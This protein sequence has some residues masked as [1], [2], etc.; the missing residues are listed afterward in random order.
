MLIK[1]RE[2]YRGWIVKDKI[3][4]LA[5]EVYDMPG[6][7]A[8]YLIET[9][10][11]YAEALKAIPGPKAAVIP[12]RLG[13]VVTEQELMAPTAPATR[14]EEALLGLLKRRQV[15]E[16]H[17]LSGLLEQLAE[18][19][20]EWERLAGLRATGEAT[21]ADI[22]AI[23]KAREHAQALEAEI[24]EAKAGQ[25]ALGA[26]I[27]EVEAE[28]GAKKLATRSED[29]QTTSRE[30]KE[31]TGRFLEMATELVDEADRIYRLRKRLDML[32][33]EIQR[34]SAGPGEVVIPMG[35]I[36]AGGS[37]SFPR[38]DQLHLNELLN[39]S[40]TGRCEAIRAEVKRLA[41]G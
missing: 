39:P 35:P 25:S 37:G 38:P 27:K 3:E 41:E 13:D 6:H 4:L 21:K 2:S 18:A 23:G 33:N 36:H 14:E 29:F 7:A 16:G 30:T 22:A 11:P 12:V 20:A 28:I 5:G 17:R 1:M 40:K 15:D 32:S 8:Q 10:P 31:R 19:R 34:L 9:G 24:T 26:R